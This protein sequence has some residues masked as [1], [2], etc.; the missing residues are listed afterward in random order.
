MFHTYESYIHN[1]ETCIATC[2]I[3][4]KHAFLHAFYMHIICH[5]WNLQESVY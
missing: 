5:S 2:F 1:C 4:M 3:R